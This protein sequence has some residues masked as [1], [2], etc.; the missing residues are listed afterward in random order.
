MKKKSI[1]FPTPKRFLPCKAQKH[2]RK[3]SSAL[4]L[5]N[6]CR[7]CGEQDPNPHLVSLHD[8]SASFR[9]TGFTDILPVLIFPFTGDSVSDI[10]SKSDSVKGSNSSPSPMSPAR[11][12]VRGEL[13]CKTMERS[14]KILNSIQLHREN[15][16]LIL[17]P[18]QIC[19]I[20]YFLVR[21][22]K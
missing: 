11:V 14:Q 8:P 5:L 3:N 7:Q 20:I 16:L 10:T 2:D 18:K 19:M 17:L 9:E 21:W 15:N 4:G 1:F 6:F 13:S 22:R 12:S